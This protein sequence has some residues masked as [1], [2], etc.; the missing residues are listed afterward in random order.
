MEKGFEW[1]WQALSPSN[2]PTHDLLVSLKELGTCKPAALIYEEA[3]RSVHLK[4]D[5]AVFVGT[6][7]LN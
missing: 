6:R 1:L 2:Y 4:V 5:E 7:H 3:C